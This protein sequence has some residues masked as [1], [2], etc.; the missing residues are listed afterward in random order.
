MGCDI[1]MVLEYQHPKYGWIGINDF[2]YYDKSVFRE[3][4]LWESDLP[5]VSWRARD[6][7]YNRFA[8][9]AGVRGQG[10]DPRGLPDD[11]SDMALANIA[12]WGEDGHSHTWLTVREALQIWLSAEQLS[13]LVLQRMETGENAAVRGA[14][15]GLFGCLSGSDGVD[16]HR[17]II[18]FDN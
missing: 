12:E 9:I 18:W 2:Q 5:W 14:A 6:R 1:H 10:P 8:K 17:L 13:E 16:K 7:D 15:E 11:I 3:S 4:G